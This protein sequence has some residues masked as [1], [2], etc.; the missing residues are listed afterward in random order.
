MTQPE[1][2]LVAGCGSIGQ[3]HITNLNRIGVS[4][5]VANDPD[6][7]ARGAAESAG[8]S[9]TYSDIES[10]LRNHDPDIGI[11]CTPN[12]LHVPVSQ[13]LA[14]AGLDLFVEKPVSHKLDEIPEL[15]EAV[16]T[17]ELVTLVGC[18]FRFHPGIRKVKNLLEA[19]AISSPLTVQIEAG[20]YLPD[21]HPEEDYQE[22]YSA[23]VEQ[24]G[25]A[26]LDYIHELN[27]ARWLFGNVKTI[28][29]MTSSQSHLDIETEDVGAI[30][31]KMTDG[32]IC[33]IHVDYVQQSASRNCKVVGD[34][35]TLTWDVDRHTVGHYDPRTNT[36]ET[37]ELPE[38]DMN[39]MY[40]S[41]MEHFLKCV[42]DRSKTICDIEDAS[43]DLQAGLAALHSAESGEH[44]TVSSVSSNP[45]KD[46]S[47]NGLEKDT[48]Q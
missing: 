22:M 38:W 11:V 10:A 23:S 20:S 7:E 35:G 40:I 42:A 36:W 9:A 18:N 44:V 13:R 3:R 30:I 31:M 17:K 26:I 6:P 14:E 29:A 47:Q 16:Q 43:H 4:E 32:V 45:T 37:H 5:I 41:E 46:G 39:K 19:G 21:W 15:I 1:S 27:Y 2:C 8:A 28:S 34:N 48:K 24:G 25:G 12:H 33:E